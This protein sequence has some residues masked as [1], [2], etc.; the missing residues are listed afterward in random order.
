[1]PIEIKVGPPTITISQGRTFMVT[2][3]SGEI[4]ANTDQGVYALDTRF[5]SAYRLYLNREPLQVV[6]SSQ[7]SFYASRFHLTNPAI[8]TDGG[9]LDAQTLR[10]T[11]NRL[12]SE[13][14]HE[15]ID[16]ANYTGKAI[17]FLLELAMRSD[18]ADL[19]EVKSQ[20]IIQRGKEQTQWNA[21]EKQLYTT[22]LP[23]LKTASLT[24]PRIPR[25]KKR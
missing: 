2:T 23:H 15:D 25:R 4:R 14:I 13:G 17:H 8:E 11:I 9:I 10:I 7:L 22:A 18:F 16:I 21:Q 19:F 5:L 6:N 3:Q 24:S 12:V 1:M 20:H